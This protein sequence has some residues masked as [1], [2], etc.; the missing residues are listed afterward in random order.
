MSSG[1]NHKMLKIGRWD[2][3]PAELRIVDGDEQHALEAKVMDVLLAL[4]ARGGGVA[5]R[6]EL[7]DEVWGK[8][9]GGDESLTRAISL[10]RKAFG[11]ERGKPEY[12]RTV[13]RKGYQL[14][15][16]VSH[17]DG[18]AVTTARDTAPTPPQSPEANPADEI[19][20]PRESVNTRR[21]GGF[22]LAALIALAA[23]V[24]FGRDLVFPAAPQPPL[25]MIMDS[26]HPARVYDDDVRNS[27]GTNADILSDILSDLP[28][29]T[30]KELIS[31]SW[32]RY[33]S[34]TQFD[35]DLI[36]IHYSGFKQEDARGPRPQLKLLIE[37]FLKSDTEFLVYSRASEAWLQEK[38]DIVLE[39]FIKDNPDLSGRVHIFP[40]TEYGESNWRNQTA[41]QGIKLKI[42]DMLE[43][44]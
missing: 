37:Y 23:M 3:S 14:I 17:I 44:E 27:G 42:K 13:P 4:V 24:T 2:V 11:D 8:E 28:I 9:F 39:E 41:A 12:I 5:L 29:R 21:W 18:I 40:L 6:D 35:P 1:D 7:I 33:E 16:P 38:M 30:Q 34:I 15:A 22:A 19:Q 20:Q 32:H 36:V 43:L 31:P 26:A 25:V 10:L